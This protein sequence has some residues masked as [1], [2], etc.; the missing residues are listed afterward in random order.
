MSKKTEIYDVFEY[1]LALQILKDLPKLREILEKTKVSLDNY[2]KYRDAA[3]VI[4]TIDDSLIMIDLQ[5]ATYESVKKAKGK[6]K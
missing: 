3:N 2:R 5:I 6:I 1:A 4:N